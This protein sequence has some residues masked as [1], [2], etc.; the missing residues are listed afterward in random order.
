[1]RLSEAQTGRDSSKMKSR[2]A[3]WVLAR[4]DEVACGL[5]R[6]PNGSSAH[7]RASPPRHKRRGA[8]VAATKD[9]FC[10]S[11]LQRA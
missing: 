11:D 10:R 5:V 3:A 7:L 4:F 6:P 8:P 1:M 9:A 2:L